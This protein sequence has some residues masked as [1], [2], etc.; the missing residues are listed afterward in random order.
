MKII[1]ISILS[2]FIIFSLLVVRQLSK[3]WRYCWEE[4]KIK[5]IYR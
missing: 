5:C 1:K 3:N 2:V 4:I